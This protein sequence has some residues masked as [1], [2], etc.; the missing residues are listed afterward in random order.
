MRHMHS[1]V[2]ASETR[3]DRPFFFFF[4]LFFSFFF[5]WVFQNQLTF[6]LKCTTTTTTTKKQPAP[7]RPRPRGLFPP[8]SLSGEDGRQ[9]VEVPPHRE[10]ALER[11]APAAPNG[12]SDSGSDSRSWRPAAAAAAAPPPAP[13]LSASRARKGPQVQ[14]ALPNQRTPVSRGEGRRKAADALGGLER[15][16]EAGGAGCYGSSP[17]DATDAK[18]EG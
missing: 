6:F 3:T 8:F 2:R 11:D 4:F 18:L 16:G 13:S 17:L 12:R 15:R 5:F 7:R 1:N 9:V 14:E 10:G